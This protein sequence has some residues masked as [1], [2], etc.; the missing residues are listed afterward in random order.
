MFT[1]IN[2]YVQQGLARLITQYVA[3]PNLR[4]L[5]TSFILSAQTIEDELTDMNNLRY[6]G[7]AQGVQLDNIGEIVGLKRAPGQSDA[8]YTQAIY[9][10]IKINTSEGQPE[11]IIQAFLLFT[12]VSQVR[13]FEE[14][15]ATVLLESTFVPVDQAHVNSLSS[16]V[17]QVFPA[18]V[19]LDGI[20]SYDPVTPFAFRVFLAPGS[21]FGTVAN[22]GVGGKF[23]TIKRF[24]LPFGF[25]GTNPNLRG[26]GTV[27][28]PLVGG[29]FGTI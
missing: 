23:G 26:F 20:V 19:K 10:Q 9:G 24:R 11:Q 7:Q 21:G 1:Q 25:A 14:Y 27:L 12:G 22:P 13:L 5:L 3:S 4:S 2:N 15:P 8:S 17:R 29:G 28:D 16:L 6:L 18:G